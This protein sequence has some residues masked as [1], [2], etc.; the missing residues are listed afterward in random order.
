MYRSGVE[1]KNNIKIES[2]PNDRSG[3]GSRKNSKVAIEIESPKDT[4]SD[5]IAEQAQSLESY[6][7][8]TNT[9]MESS[10]ST[11]KHTLP[12]SPRPQPSG[13]AP[14]QRPTSEIKDDEPIQLQNPSVK[15][16]INVAPIS[17]SL[18][19]SPR[20]QPSR[21]L[22]ESE[23]KPMEDAKTTIDKVTIS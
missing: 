7:I 1:N 3:N 5:K 19:K 21:M 4:Y 12:I 2:N 22:L 8:E 14:T 16:S 6:S 9:K 17:K 23:T 10:P 18:S 13:F 20:P 15:E 11:D